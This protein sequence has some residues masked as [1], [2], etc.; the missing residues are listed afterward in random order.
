MFEAHGPWRWGNLDGRP[1]RRPGPHG[2]P[3][4]RRVRQRAEVR[5]RTRPLRQ[6]RELSRVQRGHAVPQSLRC[7]ASPTTCFRS[8]GATAWSPNAQRGIRVP[9]CDDVCGPE[10]SGSARPGRSTSRG[11]VHRAA[12]RP[13]MSR[14]PR[15]RRVVRSRRALQP[16]ADANPA[17]LDEERAVDL[18]LS[19]R[20]AKVHGGRHTLGATPRALPPCGGAENAAGHADIS[21]RYAGVPHTVTSIATKGRRPAHLAV[22]TETS[23]TG[24]SSPDRSLSSIPSRWSRRACGRALATSFAVRTCRRRG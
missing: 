18:S 13:S 3:C 23:R 11:H 4:P 12:S 2:G 24:T 7:S 15:C 10:G 16:T 22:Q 6:G 21:R 1:G 14:R 17:R 9:S 20:V 8:R 19:T 5:N